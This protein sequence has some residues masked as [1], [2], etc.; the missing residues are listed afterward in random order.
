LDA[1]ARLTRA[2][3]ARKLREYDNLHLEIQ[4]LQAEIETEAEAEAEAATGQGSASH[5][6]SAE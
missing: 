1:K 5:G 6:G 2:F 3:L 4:R